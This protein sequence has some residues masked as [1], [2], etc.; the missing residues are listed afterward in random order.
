MLSGQKTFITNRVNAGLVIVLACTDPELGARGQPALF[1]VEEGLPGFSRAR[2][3]ARSAS[4][5]RTPAS[6][7]SMRCESR[8]TACWAS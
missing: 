3:C 7:S 6:C 2:P 8:L 4:T 5:P 1:C